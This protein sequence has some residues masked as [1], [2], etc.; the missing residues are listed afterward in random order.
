VER[1]ATLRVW[2]VRL[3]AGATALTHLAV[4]VLA[5][6]AEAGLVGPAGDALQRLG[7]GVASEAQAAARAAFAAA[8]E[9][10]QHAA[11][12]LTGWP[13]ADPVTTR[14]GRRR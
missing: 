10:D 9:L 11:L 14:E 3:R 6:C 7:R 12:L 2:S 1:I 8:D 5:G 13:D 4:I